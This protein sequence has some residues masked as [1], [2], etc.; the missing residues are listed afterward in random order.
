MSTSQAIAQH[1]PYLRRYARA[2]AGSQQSGDAYV[3]A[4]LEAL[5]SDP[6]VLQRDASTRVAL[7]KVFTKIWNSV[8]ANEGVQAPAPN[9]P[10]EAR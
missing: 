8:S 1:L 5:I 10:A 2:L 3:A 7:Y 4:T 6:K 9:M